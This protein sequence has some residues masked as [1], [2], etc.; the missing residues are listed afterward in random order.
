MNMGTRTY[1]RIARDLEQRISDDP[2]YELPS[3]RELA[4]QWNV[5]Y[6]TMW[7]A[8]QV[9]A[10]K[11]LVTL[12][13][14]RRSQAF[15]NMHPRT[16]HPPSAADRL[17]ALVKERIEN[18]VYKVNM[19]LP[20][21]GYFA[22][23][24]HV[25]YATIARAF[26]QLAGESL[27]HRKG[28]QWIA[29]PCRLRSSSRPSTG[30]YPIVLALMGE[31][32]TWS[33]LFQSP[34][35]GRFLVT[36]ANELVQH[37]VQLSPAWLWP[38]GAAISIVPTNID[39]ARSAI[40]KLGHRYAGTL[41]HSIF[42]KEDWLDK[43]IPMLLPF[44]KP[45]VYFDRVDK[46]GF[47]T[48]GALGAKGLYY[49]LHMDERA[50]VAVAVRALAESGHP[51][52]GM[53]GAEVFEWTRQR[54][55]L[56][57]HAAQQLRPPVAVETAAAMEKPW[58][59]MVQ[60]GAGGLLS[61]IEHEAGTKDARARAR[62][63][64][65]AASLVSLL[66]GGRSTALACMNDVWAHHYYLIFKFLGIR[67]P[68]DISMVAFDNIP[69]SINFPV[70]T[71]DFGFE[72]L[73]YLAAHIFIGDISI[74]ADKNGAIPGACTLVD[75]GSIDKPCDRRALVRALKP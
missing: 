2:S 58:V 39:E 24:E 61:R 23:T 11:G 48:R 21:T 37:S 50:A 6:Q 7:M 55:E 70:S 62:L 46:G 41:I 63:L 66:A 31:N 33:Q 9:L 40:R 10:S 73:G 49:R 71:I 18:G 65:D 34:F 15:R 27:V 56:I 44:E 29:G 57:T 4:S 42:P 5:A 52:I 72:R 30:A 51:V 20:K 13:K 53:H 3:I 19:P 22:I 35:V 45:I 25:S 12:A 32:D 74:S 28:R 59:D 64:K 16:D 17:S 1:E 36:F 38:G 47:L 54:A 67:V 26:F 69:E 68:Q 14:G 60:T 43:W 75:R 8:M